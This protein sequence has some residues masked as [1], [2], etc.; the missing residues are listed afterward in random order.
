MVMIDCECVDTPSALV[1]SPQSDMIVECNACI[2]YNVR[3]GW[4]DTVSLFAALYVV[5]L[6]MSSVHVRS[7]VNIPIIYMFHGSIMTQIL[8]LTN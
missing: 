7:F 8:C 1:K 6:S 2:V 4:S 5:L 3:L